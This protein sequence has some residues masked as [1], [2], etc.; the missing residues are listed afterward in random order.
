MTKT[1]QGETG[2]GEGKERNRNRTGEG[3]LDERNCGRGIRGR[4][5]RGDCRGI[6]RD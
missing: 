3:E 2:E 5:M 4:G 1:K 6:H